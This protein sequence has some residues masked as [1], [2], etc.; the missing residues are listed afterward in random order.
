MLND[1]QLLKDGAA[2]DALGNMCGRIWCRAHVLPERTSE[3]VQPYVPALGERIFVKFN[4]AAEDGAAMDV[5]YEGTVA[6]VRKGGPCDVV[7]SDG[8]KQQISF[9]NN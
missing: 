9:Y 3:T 4:E 6:V 8:E 2:I 7:F 1:N 5:W